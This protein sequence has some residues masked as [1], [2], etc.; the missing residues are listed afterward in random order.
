MGALYDAATGLCKHGS[1]GH[2]VF[3]QHPALLLWDAPGMCVYVAVTVVVFVATAFIGRLQTSFLEIQASLS[4]FLCCEPCLFVSECETVCM[5][6]S[7]KKGMLIYF[8]L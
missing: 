8:T 3:L 4:L 1:V 6:T 5:F 2:S 7:R